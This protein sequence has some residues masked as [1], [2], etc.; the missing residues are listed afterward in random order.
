MLFR[1]L[2]TRT[3]TKPL[4][5]ALTRF[6]HVCLPSHALMGS[7]QKPADFCTNF[8]KSIRRVSIG[9]LALSCLAVP[10]MATVPYVV[11]QYSRRRTVLGHDGKPQSLW[12]F[13]T[14]QLPVVHAIAQYWVLKAYAE[15]AISLF[16]DLSLGP[17]V[18]HG[19]AT[20]LKAVMIQ[21]SQA[22]LYRLSERCGAQGL[23]THTQIL[24]T[25]VMFLLNYATWPLTKWLIRLGPNAWCWNRR[26]RCIG[27]MHK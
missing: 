19:I 21:H 4:D 20:A 11:A 1:V 26:G 10:L 23:Y 9:T 18:Q 17:S 14:Q 2:P 25:Q 24:Q 22:S 3:G 5:H 8:L 6:N 16:K 7:L 15:E 27:I 13:R 12:S